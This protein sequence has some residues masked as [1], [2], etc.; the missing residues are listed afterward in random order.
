MFEHSHD[1]DH[2][3]TETSFLSDNPIW[4]QDNVFLRSL[5]LDI[6][7]SGMQAVCSSM[8]MRKDTESLSERYVLADRRIEY[9]SPIV[10]TPYSRDDSVDVEGVEAVLGQFLQDAHVAPDEIDCGVVLLTGEAQSHQ[11]APAIAD[12]IARGFEGLICATAGHG[13]E[14]VLAAHGSGAV[15][16][17]VDLGE[18]ILNVDIGGGTTKLSVAIDGRVVSTAALHI[19]GR[20]IR[21]DR[22][23]RIEGAR[24]RGLEHLAAAGFGDDLMAKRSPWIWAKVAERMADQ[25]CSAIQDG[26]AT[27]EYLLTQPLDYVER[28]RSVIFSGGVAEYIYGREERHFGDL[29]KLLGTAVRRQLVRDDLGLTVL[30]AER[31]ITATLVGTTHDTVQLSGN[32]I[33]LTTEEVLPLRN[34]RVIRVGP[35]RSAAGASGI[36]AAL[37]EATALQDLTV[38]DSDLAFALDW[39]DGPDYQ[40]LRVLAEGVAIIGR[41]RVRRGLPTSLM[42]SVDLAKTLGS[43]LVD[44]CSFDGALVV[45]D[46]VA[47]ST[48]GWVDI[49]RVQ[50]G[51]GTIPL[52]IKDLVFDRMVSHDSDRIET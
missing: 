19:G 44:E 17:S 52:T 15:G 37:Q 21:F 1:H 9:Q 26:G 35:L 47:P 12:R 11:N 39:V 30:P 33:H 23:G 29:G 10:F 20:L 6:G 45:I 28:A 3:G 13:M 31:C 4:Q 36:A 40:G 27:S 5:G 46:G 18:P 7:T 32:T 25:I 24:Q 38:Y 34:Q 2:L 8:H 49:G 50:P 14:A 43:I 16:A 51:S 48:F 22:E 42:L 41:S